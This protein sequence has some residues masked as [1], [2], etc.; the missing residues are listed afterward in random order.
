M[1]DMSD[2]NFK[3]ILNILSTI[4]PQCEVIAYGSRVKGT[5]HPGSDLNLLLK[6]KKQVNPMQLY[7]LKSAF[8]DSNLPFTVDILDWHSIPDQFKENIQPCFVI[9]QTGR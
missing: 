5:S 6:A 1:F 2:V 3:T 8:E 7:S 4:V 9:M